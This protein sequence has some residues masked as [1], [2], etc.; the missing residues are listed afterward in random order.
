MLYSPFLNYKRNTINKLNVHY[1][2]FTRF[3]RRFLHCASTDCTQLTQ[4]Q[5]PTV[6][7]Q[8]NQQLTPVKVL[9]RVQKKKKKQ[10]QCNQCKQ[11]VKQAASKLG[12]QT[13]QQ[14]DK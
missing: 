2:I 8:C 9:Y 11:T 12:Q 3:Q 6:Y 10:Q 5:A 7:T 4:L 1:L 13:N 14:T